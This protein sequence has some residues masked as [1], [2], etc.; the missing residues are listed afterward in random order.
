VGCSSVWL[1]TST[2]FIGVVNNVSVITLDSQ[3]NPECACRLVSM[4]QIYY[5]AG[6]HQYRYS[7]P[8]IAVSPPDTRTNST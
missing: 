3:I 7:Y 5:F 4:T 1:L 2:H 6:I 8:F